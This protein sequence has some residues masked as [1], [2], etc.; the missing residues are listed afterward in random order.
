MEVEEAFKELVD[1]EGEFLSGLSVLLEV[2]VFPLREA[3]LSSQPIMNGEDMRT[4][5]STVEVIHS[6]TTK[7]LN[8]ANTC[9]P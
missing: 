7:A 9:L 2:F 3:L 1:C 8:V 5:F 6:L 4:I